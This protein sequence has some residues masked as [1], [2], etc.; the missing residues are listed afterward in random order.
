ML[1]MHEI[2]IYLL[3]IRHI[4]FILVTMLI[5]SRMTGNTKEN[6]KFAKDSSDSGEPSDPSS[7]TAS[8][9]SGPPSGLSGLPLGP[10]TEPPAEPSSEPPSGPS[11][12]PPSGPKVDESSVMV[13]GM[14]P[15][16]IE[17]EGKPV[18]ISKDLNSKRAF[19]P[20]RIAFQVSLFFECVFLK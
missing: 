19:R 13:S 17:F 11:S 9:S 18:W 10:P 12:G 8:G 15:M 1:K 16:F 5:S 3:F 2:Y 4:F 6:K 7:G 20:D 14:V